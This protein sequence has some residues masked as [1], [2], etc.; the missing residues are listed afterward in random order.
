MKKFLIVI[1]L[2]LIPCFVWA[3]VD[4]WDGVTGID[5]FDGQTGI[6]KICGQTVASGGDPCGCSG[7]YMFCYT[8][9]YSGDTDK[10]CFNS[11][12][13]QK[14]GTVV[15]ASVSADYVT[16]SSTNDYI[17]WA[18]SGDDGFNDDEGTLY[19]DYYIDD[20]GNIGYNALIESYADANNYLMIYI[21]GADD[22]VIARFISNGST[23]ELYLSAAA[24][25]WV[26][27]GYTWQ[28]GADAGG[29]HA[30]SIDGGSTWGD[31]D[32]EDLDSWTTAPDDITIG[33][34]DGGVDVYEN[35]RVRNLIILSGY[36]TADPL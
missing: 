14:D 12:A 25:T 18:I 19:F 28:T 8:G 11:G 32:T 13:S 7:T 24:G 6:A 10:A 30:L 21:N 33:E 31:E 2:C 1:L 26:R 36:K 16:W 34:K 29:K 9:D 15:D 35:P 5:T 3:D 20:D 4:T 22:R 17:S 27:V 23:Q